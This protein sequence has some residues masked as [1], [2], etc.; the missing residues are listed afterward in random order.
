MIARAVGAEIWV[1][2]TFDMAA[3]SRIMKSPEVYEH[4]SDDGSPSVDDYQPID[5][6]RVIYIGIEH[7]E[8][9]QGV[10]MCVPQ[11][12]VTLEVHTCMTKPL[13]GRSVECASRAIEWVWQNTGF[14][15]IVTNVPTYNKLAAKLSVRA[16]M[17]K[18]GLNPHSFLKHGVLY[19]QTLFGISK[20]VSCPLL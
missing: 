18:Y 17:K 20:G 2:R 13:F 4:I 8:E 12:S 6:E 15:R 14:Q 11:N 7:D 10:F 3:I 19:D 5:D 16:G 9:I 1:C